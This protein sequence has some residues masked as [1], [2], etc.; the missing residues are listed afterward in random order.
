M[1]SLW[2]RLGAGSMI[3]TPPLA[4]RPASRRADLTCADA[5]EFTWLMRFNCPPRTLRGRKSPS[6]IA[7]IRRSGSR[8][9]LIGRRLNEAS[10][11]NLAS[12]SKPAAAPIIKRVQVPLLPQ[13]TGAAGLCHRVPVTVQWPFPSRSTAGPKARTASAVRRTSSLSQSPWTTVVPAA[14]PPRISARWDID[15]SPGIDM[16][17][18]RSGDA[19]ASRRS[20][21]FVSTAKLAFGMQS[22]VRFS[23]HRQSSETDWR[24]TL[25]GLTRSVARQRAW[26]GEPRTKKGSPL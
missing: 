2:S 18:L 15:L 10:P 13:S 19:N 14:R 24:L 20:S 8:I 6:A 26:T 25:S 21:P 22:N 17:P 16:S 23:S 1:F 9:R 4:W 3:S 12:K 7:P 5:T 11:M